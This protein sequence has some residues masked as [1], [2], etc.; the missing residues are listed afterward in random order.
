MQSASRAWSACL[1]ALGSAAQ[2]PLALTA[3]G[4][5]AR[6]S[7]Y[8]TSLWIV[9]DLCLVASPVIACAAAVLAGFG[10]RRSAVALALVA[11]AT[12]L[13]S[14]ALGLAGSITLTAPAP[15]DL[16]AWARGDLLG[17]GWTEPLSPSIPLAPAYPMANLT[18]PMLLIAG[19]VVAARVPAPT[20][21]RALPRG[22]A[23]LSSPT[24][25]LPTP[26]PLGDAAVIESPIDQDGGA[27]TASMRRSRSAERNSAT[28]RSY[29]S[30]PH[31]QKS[32]SIELVDS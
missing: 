23:V 5:V 26:M 19:I 30:R 1:L 27:A 21:R 7:A 29:F 13:A 6:W 12:C 32:N 8:P 11:F 14:T 31:S 10:V 9:A 2:L 3:S 24:P 16:A 15:L 4:Q 22:R 18:A 28:A 17:V 25:I 20:R